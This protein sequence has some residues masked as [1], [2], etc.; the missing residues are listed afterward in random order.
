M[1]AR[2]SHA[3]LRC[4]NW[5]WALWQGGR[6][7]TDLED[8][9]AS[10]RF[11]DRQPLR[12][13]CF[14]YFSLKCDGG[15]RSRSPP[16]P[17]ALNNR[18]LFWHC[19]V[20]LLVRVHPALMRLLNIVELFLLI[21]CEQRPNLRHCAVHHRLD[22]LHRLPTNGGDLR[23][24]LIDNRLNLRLLLGGQVYFLWYSF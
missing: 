13:Q 17:T 21:R 24:G 2:G 7:L 5:R 11:P 23:L 3:L 16:S 20:R 8:R 14:G 22:F 12:L 6:L 15:D 1:G 4:E 9:F 19:V 10:S 18:K